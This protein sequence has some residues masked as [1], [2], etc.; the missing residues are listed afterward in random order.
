MDQS[1]RERL[2]QRFSQADSSTSRRF[3]GTGLGLS[4]SKEIVV[5]MG[6]RI[7]VES[8]PGSGSLFWFE[9]ALTPRELPAESPAVPDWK[10]ILP[11]GFRVLVAEDNRTNQRLARSLLEKLGCDVLLVENGIQAV[12]AMSRG[13]FQL[14]LMDCHM[15]EMDGYEATRQIRGWKTGSDP[16]LRE[17]A[18]VPIVALTADAVPG[19]EAK[20]HEAGMDDFLA[21]PFRMEVFA[22]LLERW[23]TARRRPLPPA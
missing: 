11:V 3:G 19:N 2:F 13:G 14:V 6:G 5:A 23:S 17:L 9:I 10:A 21:K 22:A 8:E 15:P 1:S 20:C 4:I 16:S 18:D 7:Q 12:E